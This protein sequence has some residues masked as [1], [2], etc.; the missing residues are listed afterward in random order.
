[1]CFTMPLIPPLEPNTITASIL[2]IVN[3]KASFTSGKLLLGPL[4][5]VLEV[6]GLLFVHHGDGGDR[7]WSWVS[8]DVLRGVLTVAAA[9]NVRCEEWY[10][11]PGLVKV[12]IGCSEAGVSKGG[13]LDDA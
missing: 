8:Y 6:P 4:H 12:G 7:G 1:M 11:I 9:L 13:S 5:H 2:S 3:T 10:I